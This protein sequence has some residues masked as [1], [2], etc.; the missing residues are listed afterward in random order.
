MGTFLS[1]PISHVLSGRI[2]R[3]IAVTALLIAN[4]AAFADD[5]P[6]QLDRTNWMSF[7]RYKED[8]SAWQGPKAGD[9]VAAQAPVLSVPVIVP[10]PVAVP[11]LNRPINAPTMPGVNNGFEVDISSTLDSKRSV[12][13]LATNP[14]GPEGLEPPEQNWKNAAAEAREF[15]TQNK[16]AEDAE[17]TTLKIRFAFLP[18]PE[19]TPVF[20]PPKKHPRPQPAVIAQTPVPNNPQDKA[21]CAAIDAYKKRELEAIQSDRQTLAALQS[22]ITQLG[23]QKKLDFMVGANGSLAAPTPNAAMDFAVSA[24]PSVKN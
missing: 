6:F 22:A 17:S 2:L 13:S 12:D 21:A 3:A 14:D 8:P 1:L 23:L 9:Q 15:V 4:G 18:N 10:Q 11:T 16:T 7:D 5:E 19:I 24:P 20:N